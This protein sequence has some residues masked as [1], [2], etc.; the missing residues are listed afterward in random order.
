VVSL[1]GG[2]NAHPGDAASLLR[3][4]DILDADVVALQELTPGLL[5]VL[6]GEL[7]SRY[8]QSA[9]TYSAIVFSRFPLSGARTLSFLGRG[10]DAQR[11]ELQVGDHWVTLFNV[12]LTRPGYQHL[13]RRGVVRFVRDYDPTLRDAHA[14]TI[15]AQLRDARG[16]IM[17]V[18][19]LNGTEWS[20]AYQ[21]VG[22]GLGDSFREVGRGFGHTYRAG[23]S[24]GSHRLRVS[25]VRIDYVF[26]SPEL[27]ALHA[28]VGPDGGSDHLP[29]V[30]ELAFRTASG[31]CAARQS[32]DSTWSQ[33]VLK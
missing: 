11:V 1:N 10:S 26:H 6:R 15:K 8:P 2:G 28:H 7:A 31:T 21:L 24:C 20:H 23:L 30:A 18:G 16:P 14:A 17:V 13:T 19:D 33:P 4:L 3:S 25:L 32:S 22:A 5:A 27:V 9:G 29:V 12:H